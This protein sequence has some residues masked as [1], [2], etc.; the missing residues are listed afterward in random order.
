MA[1]TL[2]VAAQPLCAASQTTQPNVAPSVLFAN[3]PGGV[4]PAGIVQGQ[5]FPGNIIPSCMLNANAQSLLGAGIFPAPTNGTQFQ[6][7]P[8]TPTDVR[9]E[10]VRIDHEFNSKNTI[11]GHFVAEQIAQG[12]GTTMWSGDNVPTIGNTF[13]NPSYSAVATWTRT[14]SPTLLNELTFNYSGN[15]INITPVGIYKAPSRLHL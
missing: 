3:C 10:I 13:G 12:F 7:S 15:R 6:G 14:I 2:V 1:E 5:P 4:A 11:F 8:S 9:E